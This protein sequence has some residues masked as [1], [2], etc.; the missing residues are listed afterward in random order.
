MTMDIK[1]LL[2][3]LNEYC[4]S[5][6]GQRTDNFDDRS[7]KK[8]GKL[9]FCA[10]FG[11]LKSLTL[12][13]LEEAGKLISQGDYCEELKYVVRECLEPKPEPSRSKNESIDTLISR[14][15][16]KK[17]RRVVESRKTLKKRFP[18]QSYADQK[19]IVKA[20]LE[21][22]VAADLDWAA[23]E[24]GKIWDSSYESYVAEAFDKRETARLALLVIRHMPIDYVKSREKYLV[25]YSRVEFCI[26][27]ADDLDSLAQKYD[28]SMFEYIY[29]KARIGL[30][31]DISP[32][33][34]ERYFFRH[35]F[36]FAQHALQGT[37][38]Y[39]GFTHLSQMPWIGRALWALGELGYSDVLM[40]YL[41]LRRYIDQKCQ[42]D[43]S[44]YYYCQKW[45]NDRYFPDARAVENFDAQRILDAVGN[46]PHPQSIRIESIEDLDSYSGMSKEIIDTVSD[47]I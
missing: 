30:A 13:E 2:D 9:E 21:S 42:E 18:Y 20:F 26:R 14:F 4:C 8:S 34:V 45:L 31:P 28:L 32:D 37:Y 19:K 36:I 35:I 29:A 6:T 46:L 17:S 38:Y 15:K 7:S 39:P 23:V 40:R 44:E 41:E 11:L 47:F 16:D 24:A 22:D 1:Q 10:Y 43:E 33:D 27:L 25:M 3:Y 12:C 5:K